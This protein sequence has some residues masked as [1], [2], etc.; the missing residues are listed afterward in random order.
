MARIERMERRL[1]M[2]KKVGTESRPSQTP[3]R[4]GPEAETAATDDV[5][6]SEGQVQTPKQMHFRRGGKS[7]KRYGH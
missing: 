2:V 5:Q 3:R 1:Q 6:Q 4:K 7:L